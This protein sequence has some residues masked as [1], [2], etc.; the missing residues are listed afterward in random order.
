M[1]VVKCMASSHCL[2]VRICHSNDLDRFC[3][4]LLLPLVLRMDDG[5]IGR[6]GER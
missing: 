2:F 3:S 6:R 1:H 5:S 4:N